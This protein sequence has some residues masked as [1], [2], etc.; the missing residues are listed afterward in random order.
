MGRDRVRACARKQSRA[1]ET[2]KVARGTEGAGA[3]G[4]E[5]VVIALPRTRRGRIRCARYPA[6]FSPPHQPATDLFVERQEEPMHLEAHFTRTRLPLPCPRRVLAQ[7][8]EIKARPTLSPA[9]CFSI[10]RLGSSS[11]TKIFKCISAYGAQLID[12]A[13][14]LPLI[15]ANRLAEHFCC[16]RSPSRNGKEGLVDCRKQSA[17]TRA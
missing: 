15:G 14:E 10:S 5:L 11:S 17:M 3:G 16:C 6:A 4:C 12:I 1:A 8:A 13:E 7:I 9:R 2:R